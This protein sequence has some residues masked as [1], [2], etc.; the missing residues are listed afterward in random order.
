[1]KTKL[2]QLIEPFHFLCLIQRYM[3][4]IEREPKLF[5]PCHKR[6]FLLL[7]KHIIDERTVAEL[8]IE[9]NITT[10]TVKG[11]LD[12]AIGELV[13]VGQRL[14]KEMSNE[15]LGIDP[16]WVKLSQQFPEVRVA[17]VMS[18]ERQ[19]ELESSIQK[20]KE[21][22]LK[23]KKKKEREE[24][25]KVRVNEQTMKAYEK[26]LKETQKIKEV[27]RS[28]IPTSHPSEEPDQFEPDQYGNF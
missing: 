15:I 25:I 26:R 24:V 18:E 2:Q 27:L 21:R 16:S 3:I 23:S 10:A 9:E 6:W 12:I 8:A 19:A 20:H 28:F 14:E 11:V 5:R 22:K 13:H 7:K 4:L 1:M 17:N